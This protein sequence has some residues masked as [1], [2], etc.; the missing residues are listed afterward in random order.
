MHLRTY[1]TFWLSVPLRGDMVS[2]RAHDIFS[3]DYPS[4][5]EHHDLLIF[6]VD[7]TLTAYKQEIGEQT[8]ELLKK[9]RQNG[10]SI[11]IYSNCS[12]AR[13]EQLNKL[14]QP[15]GIFN[16]QRSDKPH[17]D[18]F[19]EVTAEYNIPPYRTVMVGDKLGTDIFGSYLAGFA[20]RI[21]VE[22]Y[23]ATRGG[24]KADPWN[25]FVRLFEKLVYFGIFNRDEI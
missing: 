17:P 12:A 10:W 13:T 3:I 14:L 9:L 25:R 22:P 18:G 4:L 5:A 21:L 8:L 23:S 19:F 24:R 15:L 11:G 16:V 20:K 7:D 1:L 2:S 6:D